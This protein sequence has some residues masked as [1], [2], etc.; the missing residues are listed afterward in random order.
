M[1]KN[2]KKKKGIPLYALILVILGIVLI[3]IFIN[4]NLNKETN[5]GNISNGKVNYS[6]MIVNKRFNKDTSIK[7]I[8]IDTVDDQINNVV[9]TNKKIEKIKNNTDEYTRTLKEVLEDTKT[10]SRDIYDINKA[11]ELGYVD[12]N[13][14]YCD[15]YA[16]ITGFKNTNNF[17]KFC[18]NAFKLMEKDKD[19]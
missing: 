9:M 14:K 13:T 4:K 17:I 10:I 3:F 2:K 16:K 8:E 6:E 1:S 7:I 11:I 18:E 5:A 15:Y 19:L 12:E